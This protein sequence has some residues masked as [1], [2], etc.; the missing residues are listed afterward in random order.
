M[1]SQVPKTSAIL[2][3]TI[4]LDTIFVFGAL[5][6][7]GPEEKEVDLDLRPDARSSNNEPS[8]SSLKSISETTPTRLERS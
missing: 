4:H 2:K 6:L 1:F 5:P 8:V 3:H 7:F